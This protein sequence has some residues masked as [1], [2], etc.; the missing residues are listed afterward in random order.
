MNCYELLDDVFVETPDPLG[1]SDM[2]IDETLARCGYRFQV[3]NLAAENYQAGIALY[4]CENDRF[5]RFYIDLMGKEQAIGAMIARDF[6]QLVMTFTKLQ[7]L[8]GLF[9]LD[10]TAALHVLDQS[11]VE[12]PHP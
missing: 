11:R 10:Q 3:G 7:G 12:Y 1:E 2:D 5:P 4:V 8:L 9:R 6:P